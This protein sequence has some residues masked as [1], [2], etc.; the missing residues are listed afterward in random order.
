MIYYLVVGVTVSAGGYYTYRRVTSKQAK[1]TEHTTNLKEK[2]KAELHPLQ[3]EKENVAEAEKA[4]SEA[5]EVSV[6]EAEVVGA[7]EIPEAAVEDVEESTGPGGVEAAPEEVTAVGAETEPKVANAGMG[8]TAEVDS[9]MTPEAMNAAADEAISTSNDQGTK[10]NDSSQECAELE[11]TSPV[12]SEPSAG[13]LQAEA[14]AG[15]EAASG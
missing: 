8:D 3:G 14:D 15:S 5:L 4:S 10:E 12:D 1:H 6:V 13:H 11:E 2:T 9:E 7:E